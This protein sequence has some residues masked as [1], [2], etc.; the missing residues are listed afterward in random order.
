MAANNDSADLEALFDSI[1]SDYS[2][3]A[4]AAPAPAPAPAPVAG[5]SGASATSDSDD[6][7]ALFDS[8]AAETVAAQ[9]PVAPAAALAL[10]QAIEPSIDAA[11]VSSARA[12]AS[13]GAVVTTGALTD[14]L[15]VGAGLGFTTVS[16]CRPPLPPRNSGSGPCQIHGIAQASPS[17]GLV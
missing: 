13:V 9:V 12:S 7:Q 17:S 6:L 4:T 5:E 8:V 14:P 16:S 2:S 3:A 10:F 15:D 11:A 1:S